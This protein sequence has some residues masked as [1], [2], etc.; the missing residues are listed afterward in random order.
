MTSAYPRGGSPDDPNY[1]AYLRGDSDNM[2][3]SPAVSS[4][5][6]LTVDETESVLAAE[7]EEDLRAAIQQSIEQYR[8]DALARAQRLIDS[9]SKQRESTSS[10]RIPETRTASDYADRHYPG[11][12]ARNVDA[13][14]QSFFPYTPPA[15]NRRPVYSNSRRASNAGVVPDPSEADTDF[16]SVTTRSTVSARDFDNAEAQAI[17]QYS[18][19][20]RGPGLDRRVAFDIPWTPGSTSSAADAGSL[21]SRSDLGSPEWSSAESNFAVALKDVRTP[22]QPGYISAREAAVS[23]SASPHGQSPL[24]NSR[25]QNMVQ[26]HNRPTVDPTMNRQRSQTT[27]QESP[28]RTFSP[29]RTATPNSLGQ[30][31]PSRPV[32]NANSALS[33]TRP[34]NNDPQFRT[35]TPT[36]LG[37]MPSRPTLNLSSSPSKAYWGWNTVSLEGRCTLVSATIPTFA[38]DMA[39]STS[40]GQF[41]TGS[42]FW[43]CS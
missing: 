26:A 12:S 37:C 20:R 27:I 2:M 25:G 34:T 36:I 18:G 28:T 5:S 17:L 13:V 42:F 16:P 23:T 9:D 21:S 22:I 3:L 19:Y 43:W 6:T 14:G 15:A 29:F 11:A 38:C 1:S 35:T 4:T 30:R 40:D 31:I 33:N 8:L 7:E 24:T 41:Q 10:P 32:L 39:P